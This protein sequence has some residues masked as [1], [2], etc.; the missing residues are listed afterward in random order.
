MILEHVSLNHG[1]VYT[2]VVSFQKSRRA[3]IGPAEPASAGKRDARVVST[4]GGE[5]LARADGQHKIRKA[6]APRS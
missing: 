6:R 2:A 1:T 3:R 4:E 5:G